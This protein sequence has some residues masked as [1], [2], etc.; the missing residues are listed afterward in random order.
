MYLRLPDYRTIGHLV[1]LRLNIWCLLYA[2]LFTKLH[3]DFHSEFHGT[4]YVTMQIF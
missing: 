2:V 1:V 3:P 4:V